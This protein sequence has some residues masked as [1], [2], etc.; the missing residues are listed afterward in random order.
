MSY[1]RYPVPT[2]V[3]PGLQTGSRVFQGLTNP[4]LPGV[5]PR[6]GV[7]VQG[8][9]NQG[10]TTQAP[11]PAGYVDEPGKS[12]IQK[13]LTASTNF[14][15][16]VDLGLTLQI[17]TIGVARPFPRTITGR[18]PQD[19]PQ[20]ALKSRFYRVVKN[21]QGV[22]DLGLTLQIDTSGSSA[23]I[24]PVAKAPRQAHNPEQVSLESRTFFP[25]SVRTG[26]V[27]LG[28]TLQIDT[29]SSY[30]A[31]PPRV[32]RNPEAH[33]IPGA[34]PQS[35]TVGALVPVVAGVV[36]LGLTL[37][38]DT[39]GNLP[40]APRLGIA[41]AGGTNQY[42]KVKAPDNPAPETPLLESRGFVYYNAAPPIYRAIV[43]GSTNQ[44]YIFEQVPVE[45]PV[46][47]PSKL[48]K[49]YASPGTGQVDLGLGLNIDTTGAAR[50][51]PKTVRGRDT[52]E[53]PGH[54]LGS[55]WFKGYVSQFAQIDLGINLNID[56][57]GTAVPL[58][59][60]LR[61]RTPAD[62]PQSYLESRI[63]LGRKNATGVVDFGLILG[64]DTGG[65]AAQRPVITRGRDTIDPI[66]RLLD[67]RFFVVRKNAEGQVDLPLVFGIGV[68]GL[69]GS[70]ITYGRFDRGTP[71]GGYDQG[72][73][74]AGYDQA[75]PAPSYDQGSPA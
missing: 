39:S 26:V 63:Y 52:I 50:P 45:V 69:S 54:D 20:R 46:T 42:A 9:T 36:D 64:I 18:D 43:P 70:T 22:V 75:S 4:A 24:P 25:K 15:G 1:V 47:P 6:I 74:E 16:V 30:S 13:K 3:D 32:Y 38:I 11:K 34:E 12:R 14:F 59:K 8:R 56:T 27:D 66:Q 7:Q 49:G 53:T 51:F 41:I 37:Q 10:F 5:A 72:A 71:A 57:T 40:A 62:S 19:A 61:G 21:A 68:D 2:Y 48:I 60:G 58:S 28:L 17:D 73:P 33:S 23:A 65:A 55:R 35:H 29:A 44:G 31:V 67:S